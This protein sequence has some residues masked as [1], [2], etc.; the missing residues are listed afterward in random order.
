MCADTYI[1]NL[2]PTISLCIKYNFD[3]SLLDGT[4]IMMHLIDG[5][6]ILIHDHLMVH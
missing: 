4:L 1:T 2:Y 6:Q 3:T 5:T